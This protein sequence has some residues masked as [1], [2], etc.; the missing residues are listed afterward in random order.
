[1]NKYGAFAQVSR[2]FLNDRLTLSAGIRIDGNDYSDEM[3][4]PLQQLSPRFSAAYAIT[5]RLGFNFNTGIYY[6]LPAYTILGYQEDGQF[7]NRENGVKYIRNN[8]F[9][10][11]FEYNVSRSAKV[12]VEGYYKGYSDYPFLLNDSITIANLGGDFGVIGNAPVSSDARGRTYG[13][14]VLYQQKL[15]KGFYGILA[16]TLGWTEFEDKNGEFRPSS[17]DSRHIVAITAGKR[18]KKNIEIG[19]R[20]RFQSGLPFTPDNDASSLVQVWDITGRAIPDYDQL[21]SLRRPIVHELDFRIDK[22]WA[23]EKWSLNLYLDL[24]NA[25]AYQ[26]QQTTTVLDRDENGDAVIIN[27]NDPLF[28]QRY[29]TKTLE[30]NNGQLLPTLGIIVEF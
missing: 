21:N 2:E 29:R 23:Y 24:E 30:L 19:L 5:E 3:S 15:Y 10:A 26:T 13:M 16:Y 18:F 28:S 20:W 6:Q 8:H 12:T 25:Y 11:G 7:V 27:P 17:W 14:E 1:M 9:V 4:N 22:K